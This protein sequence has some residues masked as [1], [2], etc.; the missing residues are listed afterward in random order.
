MRVQVEGE[1][2]GTKVLELALA[3]GARVVQ[4]H[5]QRETLEDL[6]LRDALKGGEKDKA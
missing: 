1:A 2:G 5:E 4:L 6:F 3:H